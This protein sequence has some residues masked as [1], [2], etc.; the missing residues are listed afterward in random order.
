MN[1]LSIL[2]LPSAWEVTVLR[3]LPY[4]AVSVMEHTNLQ[5]QGE[6]F[7]TALAGTHRRVFI[8]S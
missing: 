7:Q 2:L 4:M 5:G 6:R 1:V 3:G 8:L